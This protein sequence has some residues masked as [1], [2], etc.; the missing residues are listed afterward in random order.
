MDINEC[1][2]EDICDEG[3]VCNNTYGS[4]ECIKK[5][6]TKPPISDLVNPILPQSKLSCASG[7]IKKGDICVGKFYF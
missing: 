6:I 1:L 3:Y 7:Y 5:K 2:E 4:F